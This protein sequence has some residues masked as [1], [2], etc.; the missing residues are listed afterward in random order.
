MA[1]NIPM[2][3]KLSLFFWIKAVKN[4]K[5]SEFQ[6]S[7]A[8][9][10]KQ[11]ID[12]QLCQ[13]WVPFRLSVLEIKSR[14]GTKN[15]LRNGQFSVQLWKSMQL[16]KFEGRFDQLH[17]GIFSHSFH[18]LIRLRLNFMKRPISHFHQKCWRFSHAFSDLFGPS[19]MT[20]FSASQ[21]S[22]VH[23]EAV[24]RSS[25][26]VWPRA[27]RRFWHCGLQA[28]RLSRVVFQTSVDL[29]SVHKVINPNRLFARISRLHPVE[30]HL[31]FCDIK[32]YSCLFFFFF[33][34]QVQT[35]VTLCCGVF[36]WW[37]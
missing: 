2:F 17:D 12:E 16:S 5:E 4:G 11:S 18:Q 19:V 7:P 23:I 37:D 15:S 36:W 6:K 8:P 3:A 10:W 9:C 14:E 13:V 34:T 24:W 35:P 29:R 33:L 31:R 28:L 25:Q 22:V 1:L 20:L 21:S 32:F 27:I 30:P 26:S